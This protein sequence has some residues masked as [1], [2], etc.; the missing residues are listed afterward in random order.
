MMATAEKQAENCVP[1][2]INVL[3]MDLHKYSHLKGYSTFFENRLI[4]QAYQTV[5][6]LIDFHSIF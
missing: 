1:R 5:S 2:F 4:L 6:G 3:V